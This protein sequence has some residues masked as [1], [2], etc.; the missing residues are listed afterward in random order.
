MTQDELKQAVACA[1][2]KYVVDDAW[3]GVGSGSTANF[4]VD[5]LAKLKG[6][7]KGAVASSVKTARSFSMVSSAG[8]LR[9]GADMA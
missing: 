3:I 6:R 7:I 4:F 5:E 8:R 2:L 1:A 9:N